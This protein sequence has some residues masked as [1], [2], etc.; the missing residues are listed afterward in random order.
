MYCVIN[1]QIFYRDEITDGNVQ[2]VDFRFFLCSARVR[3]NGLSDVGLY[4]M[5]E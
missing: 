3:Y 4:A 1:L 5:E 2:A